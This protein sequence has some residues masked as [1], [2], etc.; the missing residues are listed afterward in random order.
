MDDDD[1]YEKTSLLPLFLSF[2]LFRPPKKGQTRVG[3]I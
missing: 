1:F 3:D 2:F